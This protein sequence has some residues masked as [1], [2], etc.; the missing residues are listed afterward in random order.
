MI[1]EPQPLTL[2]TLFRRDPHETRNGL[3]YF[4]ELAIAIVL[5]VA[6]MVFLREPYL[7]LQPGTPLFIAARL[8]PVVP[9]WLILVVAIRHY[10]RI[11]ELERLQFLQAAS[12]AAGATICISWSYPLVREAFG[13]QPLSN[14]WPMHFWLLFALSST[15]LKRFGGNPRAR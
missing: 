12:L 6:T 1:D 3:R 10:L 8:A 5:F 14:Q 4:A 13:W 11:D 2:H 15:L 7:R 9:I